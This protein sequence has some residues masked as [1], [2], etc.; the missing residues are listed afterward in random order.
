[1]LLTGGS[2]HTCNF[3]KPGTT[4]RAEAHKFLVGG[5]NMQRTIRA[6]MFLFLSAWAAGASAAEPDEEPAAGE[7]PVA[8]VADSITVTSASRRRE[9]IAEAP[10]AMSV[11]TRSEIERQASHGQVPKLL[12]N[13]PGVELTQN[14]LYDFN[15]NLRGF[16]AAINRRVLVLIDG[17][18]ASMPFTGSQEWPAISFPL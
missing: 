17:R 7:E 12:E 15:L 3:Q 6:F 2:H 1:M 8:A 11:V 13:A 9:R 5:M 18:D 16:N 4:W 14:G 10:A